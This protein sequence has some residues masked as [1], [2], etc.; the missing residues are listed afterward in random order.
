LLQKSRNEKFY[1]KIQDKKVVKR[2]M[3][4]IVTEPKSFKLQTSKAGT[5]RYHKL[6][7]TKD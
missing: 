2:E 6:G 4:N 5:S 3:L 7:V 1:K